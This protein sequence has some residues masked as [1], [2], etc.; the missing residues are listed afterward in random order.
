MANITD[1]TSSSMSGELDARIQALPQEL[2][3]TILWFTDGFEIPAIVPITK[4]EDRHSHSH[5]PGSTLRRFSSKFYSKHHKPPVALQLNR[6][7]RAKFAQEYYS[8]V[9][10]ECHTGCLKDLG[11]S[12]HW[13]YSPDGDGGVYFLSWIK[14]L[15]KTHRSING[16]IQL[17]ELENLRE[18]HD[19]CFRLLFWDFKLVAG[20]LARDGENCLDQAMLL[21]CCV[22][23]G[24]DG[25]EQM[26]MFNEEDLHL[27]D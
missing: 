25:G 2:Q 22:V 7:L 16:H 19:I 26:R 27:L 23:K 8:S 6:S 4:V 24:V 18:P 11:G 5:G 20:R 3:D 17:T 13:Q 10:F 21:L 12:R 9:T 14:S 1:K 15:S